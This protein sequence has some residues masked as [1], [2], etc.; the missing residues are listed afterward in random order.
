[1]VVTRN[2]LTEIKTLT[3]EELLHKGRLFVNRN[4]TPESQLPKIIPHPGKNQHY[5]V[6]LISSVL[7]N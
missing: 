3:S 2:I 6:P 5:A 4:K 1:M 7:S